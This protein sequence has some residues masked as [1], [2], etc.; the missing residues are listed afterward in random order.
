MSGDRSGRT[1]A[2]DAIPADFDV[3]AALAWARMRA[4]PGFLTEREGR[5][6]ALLAAATPGRGT[7]FEIGTFKG[8]S[9]VGLA[10]IAARY[11]FPP[12]VT[13]DPHTAPA[14]TDPDL[15]GQASSWRDF[16]ATLEA[17]G[18]SEAVEA[19]RAYSRELARNWNR[20]IRLLWIDG[21][22]TYRGAKEDFDLFLPHLVPGGIVALHDALHR[23]EG[24]IRVMVDDM[25]RS[26]RFGPAGFCGSIAWAQHRPRDGSAFRNSR[27][28]LAR[29][30][31]RLIPFAGRPLSRLERLRYQV[32]RA[33]VPHGSVEPRAWAALVA[34]GGAG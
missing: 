11:G 12:V 8:K 28:A 3:A 6:L 9:T 26:D 4:A 16:Q 7:I 5:F 34:Q 23:F 24:P 21:D 1:A 14:V 33:R 20:L 30:A 29:R 2:P 22:H 31:A 17:A 25:L 27:D 19:H 10:T 18:V 15:E 13:V 32:H